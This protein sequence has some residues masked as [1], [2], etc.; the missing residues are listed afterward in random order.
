MNFELKRKQSGFT[1]LTCAFK[2]MYCVDMVYG[3][4]AGIGI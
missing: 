2:D 4:D 3:K 1:V